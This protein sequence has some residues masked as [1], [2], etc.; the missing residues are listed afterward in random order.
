[1]ELAAV[2][3]GSHELAAYRGISLRY[4]EALA[5]LLLLQLLDHV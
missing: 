3:N 4:M 5:T 2:Y 1:M